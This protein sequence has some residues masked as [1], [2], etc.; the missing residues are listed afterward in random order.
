MKLDFKESYIK[1]ITCPWVGFK[2]DIYTEIWIYSKNFH[3][4]MHLLYM[5]NYLISY[6]IHILKI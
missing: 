3:I 1:E 5:E 6:M 2:K 4:L